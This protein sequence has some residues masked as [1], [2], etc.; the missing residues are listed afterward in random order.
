MA[1]RVIIVDEINE[2]GRMVASALEARGFCVVALLGSGADLKAQMITLK[3]DVVIIDMDSPDRDILENMR[4][5]GSEMPRPIVMFARN[6]DPAII[7][8]AVEAGVS[9][10]VVDGLKPER[11]KPII[12]VAIARFAHFQNIKTELDKARSS[13][14]ERKLIEKAKGILMRRRQCDEETAFA[15]MRKM[16]MDQKVRLADV[17]GKIIE[18]AELLG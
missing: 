9:A 5:V 11:I 3:A 1:F 10:Y 8:A 7:Q 14:A 13:L 17:A 16:A 15:A 18:A 4:Q 2:R 12:D 6:D